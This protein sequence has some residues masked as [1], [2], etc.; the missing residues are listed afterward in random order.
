M[1]EFR[2]IKL[3]S[4]L[5]IA[6]TFCSSLSSAQLKPNQGYPAAPAWVP[7]AVF[8]EIYPQTF[9]DTDG[10][11]IGD[12]KGIIE[13]LDYVKSLGFNAIW[14][15]PFYESP[16][17]D[18][19]YD[20]S[21]FYKVAPRYGTLDDAKRLLNE[22]H[23]RGLKVIFDFVPGH[24][25]IDHPWFKESQKNEPNK[26][27]NWYVWT[28]NTWD[29]GGPEFAGK[30]VNGYSERNGNYMMNFFWHQPALNFGFGKPDPA[31]PWQLPANHPDVLALRAEM[32]NVMKYWLNLGADGFRIDMAGSLTKNDPDSKEIVRW[33]N[34]VRSMLDS[35]YPNAFIV[36]EWSYPKAALEAGFHADFL[37]WI[38][39]YE[40]LFRKEQSRSL[41]GVSPDGKS[42]FD[43]DGKGDISNFIAEYLKQ[44]NDT[45]H[46][47]FISIPVGNH[48]LSRIT[49]NRTDA[50]LEVIYAFLMT[51]PG[52]PFFYYGDEI[53]MKQLDINNY[54]E[55]N[56][57]PRAGARTPMQWNSSTNAGFSKGPVEKLWLPIDQSPNFP[58]VE[59][60]IKNPSS[61]FHATKRLIKLRSTEKA[62]QAQAD[63]KPLFAE[64]GKYPF[65]FL[66]T[67]DNET[68][69]VALNPSGS[70]VAI[71]LN[72]DLIGNPILIGGAKNT[73][74]A[75]KGKLA[76]KMTGVSY[77]IYKFKK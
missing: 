61:I 38:G 1:L 53:G 65:V 16:F 64:K 70:E 45:K 13:K 26:Y 54:K 44:Y 69:L 19:G 72:V 8:Y 75:K 73:L 63:F 57:K 17:R 27:S 36:A 21:D 60:A 77:S 2:E 24:T 10:N 33:W 31:K 37:H 34:E 50:D 51:M 59:A 49:N 62:L 68:I 41:N 52:V 46:K 20:V 25:S 66:R 35:E 3:L 42:F 5:T 32:K 74:N 18:A 14:L 39:A 56:Y 15:N 76:M 23:K 29:N 67:L 58:N 71:D 43:K 11:G 12:L 30:M 9:Y 7:G 55:G 48:D 22:A 40:D 47:G 28:N 4:L 6:L